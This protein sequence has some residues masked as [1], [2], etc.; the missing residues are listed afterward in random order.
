MDAAPIELAAAESGMNVAQFIAWAVGDAVANVAYGSHAT[1]FPV[2]C[3]GER[4]VIRH[5]P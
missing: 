5:E 2:T 3:N 4:V 1:E